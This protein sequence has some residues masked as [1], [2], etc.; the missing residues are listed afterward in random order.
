MRYLAAR[1]SGSS[2]TSLELADREL[3]RARGVSARTDGL[4]RWLSLGRPV[5]EV[6]FDT[7]GAERAGVEYEVAARRCAYDQVRRARI[8][9]P[10]VSK[11]T[12]E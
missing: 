3:P 5:V 4:H 7:T 8:V 11:E 9:L 1:E 6:E 2:H 12:D 10:P